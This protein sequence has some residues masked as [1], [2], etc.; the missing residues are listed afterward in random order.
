MTKEI[1]N[2]NECEERGGERGV[3]EWIRVRE[4]MEQLE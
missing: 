3:K 4:T 2:E 1:E